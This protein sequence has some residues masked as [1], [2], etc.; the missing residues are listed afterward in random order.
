MAASAWALFDVARKFLGNNTYSL[1]ASGWK[2]SLHSNTASTNLSGDTTTWASVGSEI[3]ARTGY[4]TGGKGLS[5]QVW[6][7][8]ASAGQYKWDVTDPVF[9]ATAG[10]SLTSVRFAVIYYSTG[11]S[12]LPLCYAPL[13]TA[14]FSVASGNTMTIQMNASGVFTLT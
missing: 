7:T 12:T 6:T 2:L 5:G 11:T 14:E 9:T 10:S 13:S 4:A 1:S 3:T 8:G